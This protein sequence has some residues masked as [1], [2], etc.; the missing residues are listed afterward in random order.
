MVRALLVT[1]SLKQRTCI[2]LHLKQFGQFT[3]FD[4]THQRNLN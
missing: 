4:A 1:K 3:R 2:Y